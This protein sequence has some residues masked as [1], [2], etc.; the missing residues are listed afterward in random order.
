MKVLGI[1]SVM[2]TK[3]IYVLSSSDD[4]DDEVGPVEYEANEYC[5]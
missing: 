3:I 4:S 1:T 2:M 5:Q